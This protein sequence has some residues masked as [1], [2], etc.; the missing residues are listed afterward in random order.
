MIRWRDVCVC[1]SRDVVFDETTFWDWGGHADEE[2]ATS[3]AFVEF[4]VEN[5]TV[6][7]Y[8]GVSPN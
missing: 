3:D 1:V 8:G 7:V 5:Y 6:P 2:E 4:S